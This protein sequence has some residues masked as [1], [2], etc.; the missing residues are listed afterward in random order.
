MHKPN[1][2]ERRDGVRVKRIVTVRH[3]LN[4]RD[5]KKRE[6]VWQ[7]A[8]TEDMSYS[9]LLFTSVL[10]YK[11]NDTVELQ[12]VMSGVLFLFNGFGR[13]IRVTENKDKDSYQIAV[14]YVDL[15]SKN[16][17]RDAKSLI[18]SHKKETAKA[19]SKKK[20]SRSSSKSK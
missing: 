6:D 3:R 4:K 17:H 14:K 13:V 20:S 10:P 2:N 19:P 1:F 18:A 16:R 15:K 8:T 5:N 11:V 12:V 9:G 7:L